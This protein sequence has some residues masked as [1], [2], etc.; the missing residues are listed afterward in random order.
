MNYK[1][2]VKYNGIAVIINY[3]VFKLLVSFK[4]NQKIQPEKFVTQIF[5]EVSSV[6]FCKQ[7]MITLFHSCN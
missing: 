5:A 3:F 2:T 6:E 7:L 1:I 4:K